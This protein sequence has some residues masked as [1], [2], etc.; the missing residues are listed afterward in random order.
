MT[1]LI[2][3]CQYQSYPILGLHLIIYLKIFRNYY[4]RSTNQSTQ[5][6]FQRIQKTKNVFLLDSNLN[7]VSFDVSSLFTSVLLEFI[8]DVILQQ[9]YRK[10]EILTNITPN[11]L[12][13][14]LQLCTK[15]VHF[16]FN[17]QFYLQKDGITMGSPL[18]SVM[19]G[20]FMVE[21]KRSLSPVLS[22]YLT[23]LKLYVDDNIAYVKTDA[24]DHVL[25]VVN[26]FHGN[27]SFTSEQ[28]INGKISFLDILIL[29]NGNSFETTVHVKLTHNDIYLPWESF[30][31]NAWKRATLRTLLLRAHITIRS[32]DYLFITY[33]FINHYFSS[34]TTFSTYTNSNRLDNHKNPV[35]L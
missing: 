19:G 21:W 16:S 30:A 25:S 24:I 17:G 26:S 27:I 15:N 7:L 35:A 28:K 34:N 14:L 33:L 11:E 31:L 9:I 12:K 3:F 5:L 4:P 22:S 10:K 18:G 8:I 29:W 23:S 32:R 6:K 13:E 1:P 2:N 20:I